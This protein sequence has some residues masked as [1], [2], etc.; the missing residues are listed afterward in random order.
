MAEAKDP[1]FA[2][3]EVDELAVEIA[4]CSLNQGFYSHMLTI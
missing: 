3:I 1:R 4:V 2:G